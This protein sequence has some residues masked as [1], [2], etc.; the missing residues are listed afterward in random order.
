MPA[1]FLLYSAVFRETMIDLWVTG[2]IIFQC[3]VLT[4]QFIPPLSNWSAGQFSKLLGDVMGRDSAVC[5]GICT[6]HSRFRI[7][8]RGCDFYLFKN[9]QTSSDAHLMSYKMGTEVPYRRVLMTSNPNLAP[10]LIISAAKPPASL[11]VFKRIK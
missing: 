8:A 1:P 9:I 3:L 2:T 6:A 11:N 5:T 7:P 4:D 10:R